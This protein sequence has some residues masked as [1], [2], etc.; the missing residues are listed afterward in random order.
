MNVKVRFLERLAE[1]TGIREEP[2]QSRD[3]VSPRHLKNS[4]KILT[5]RHGR[6]FQDY[7][8][9]DNG[10]LTSHLQILIDGVSITNF[11]GLKTELEENAVVFIIPMV[12]GG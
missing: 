8:F 6:A 11:Q 2:I 7:V 3:C 4:L 1:I 9:E 10:D 12:G 5:K